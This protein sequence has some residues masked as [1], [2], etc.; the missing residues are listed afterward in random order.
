MCSIDSYAETLRISPVSQRVQ[1]RQLSGN[2]SYQPS[3]TTCA[4][5]TA[6]PKHFVSAQ[7]HNM[8]SID[9]YAETLRI[10]PVSQ[11]VQYR[12]LSGNT[13][14]QPSFT[15]CA[16]S[17]AKWKHFVSAQLHHMCSIDSYAETLRIS[18]VSQRVQ[19]RQLS[20]NTSYQP[21]FTTCAVSTATPKHF[22]SAQ[23][24]NVCSIDRSLSTLAVLI[25]NFLF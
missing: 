22:V 24:H 17:T 7:F 20:G 4:V 13:S 12:Q 25:F 18:P 15:T 23:F 9:S 1:Y 6:T 14:Y 2:T 21:S 19:Y 5:S 3:F 8:C 10:S 11:R 16:V